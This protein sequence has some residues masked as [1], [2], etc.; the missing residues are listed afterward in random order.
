MDQLTWH[1][2]ERGDY[3]WMAVPA[4]AAWRARTSLLHSEEELGA[5]TRNLYVQNGLCNYVLW[6]LRVCTCVATRPQGLS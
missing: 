3:L 6:A 2:E 1:T 5:Y 4:E